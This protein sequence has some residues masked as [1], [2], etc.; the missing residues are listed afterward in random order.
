MPLVGLTC[1]S[2]NLNY[3]E[4]MFG[5]GPGEI[6][7][8]RTFCLSAVSTI[9]MASASKPLKGRQDVTS[10]PSFLRH[11]LNSLVA[12]TVWKSLGHLFGV[13]PESKTDT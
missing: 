11:D 1:I 9:T 6:L 4:N 2:A 10:T 12:G 13:C 8:G 5:L 3:G 7:I